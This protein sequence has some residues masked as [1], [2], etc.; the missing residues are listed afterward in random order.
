V[1]GPVDR[2]GAT[3]YGGG[4]KVSLP[5]PARIYRIDAAGRRTLVRGAMFSPASMRVLRRIRA[6]GNVASTVP[7]RVPPGYNG[8]FAAETGVE[9][10]LSETVD[11][12]VSSPDLLLDGL[13]LLVERSEN[14]RLP[15]L[16]HPLRPAAAA[17]ALDDEDL[18]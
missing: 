13:E 17:P 1:L 15:V 9:G 16:A 4:R 11:V 12:Q 3:G 5:L 18:E 14:E 6:V 7:M 8:G 10:I 2:E